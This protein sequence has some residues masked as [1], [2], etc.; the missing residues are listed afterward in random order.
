MSNI[1]LIAIFAAL[2]TLALFA[3][4]MLRRARIVARARAKAADQFYDRAQRI[5]KSDQ[6]TDAIADAI[7]LLGNAQQDSKFIRI[8]A[9]MWL[10]GRLSDT[11]R[12]GPTSEFAK[13]YLAAP[14]E[15]QTLIQEAL[16]IGFVNS[17]YTSAIFG[18][19]VRWF[20]LRPVGMPNNTNDAPRFAGA[21]IENRNIARAA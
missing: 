17:T 18:N 6:T 11:S 10:T 19:V 5:L 20:L 7:V 13:D 4:P 12:A 21:M 15:L 2:M 14:A 1:I 9:L 16:A 8:F 3:I